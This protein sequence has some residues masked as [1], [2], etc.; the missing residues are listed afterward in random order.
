VVLATAFAATVRA[1]SATT[2]TAP[3]G[4]GTGIDAGLILGGARTVVVDLLWLRADLRRTQGHTLELP[5]LYNVIAELDPKNSLAWEYHADVLIANL[6]LTAAGEPDGGWRYFRSGLEL[7]QRGLA[8]DPA[9]Q[10][11]TYTLALHATRVATERPAEWRT[12]AGEVLGAD[13]LEAAMVMLADAHAR[14]GHEPRITILLK[15]VLGYMA[16]EASAAGRTE[17]A[18]LLRTTIAKLQAEL[19]ALPEGELPQSTHD[20]EHQHDNE[21]ERH[22]R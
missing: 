11:L 9:N 8:H 20:H 17:E 18:A 10:G 15:I 7:L 21:H 1:E 22:G 13:P 19:D 16:V 14:P 12:Q 3:V 5:A 4:I 6:P 2:P